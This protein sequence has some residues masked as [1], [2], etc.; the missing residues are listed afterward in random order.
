MHRECEWHPG[1]WGMQVLASGVC[2]QKVVGI[3]TVGAGVGHWGL[4]SVRNMQAVGHASTQA[5]GG[6]RWGGSRALRVVVGSASSGECRRWVVQVVSVVAHKCWQVP[7]RSAGQ[8]GLQEGVGGGWVVQGN[9][10]RKVKVMQAMRSVQIQPQ[11]MSYC[12]GR[13]LDLRG[14]RGAKAI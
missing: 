14:R 3:P 9:G 7:W 8:W 11:V 12:R 1:R 5:M 6:E 2:L 10:V 4:K 13:E